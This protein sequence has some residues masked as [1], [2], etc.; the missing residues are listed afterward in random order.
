MDHNN[1][2][3]KTKSRRLVLGL[4]LKNTKLHPPTASAPVSQKNAAKENIL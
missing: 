1:S 2:L 3:A 4:H